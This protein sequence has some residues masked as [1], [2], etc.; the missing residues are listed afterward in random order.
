MN[1]ITYSQQR[2][3][4]ARY[5]GLTGTFTKLSSHSQGWGVH[6]GDLGCHLWCRPCRGTVC[7]PTTTCHSANEQGDGWWAQEGG[8][9]QPVASQP[10]QQCLPHC[11]SSPSKLIHPASWWA[12]E[13]EAAVWEGGSHAENPLHN[14]SSLLE[15]IHHSTQA[16]GKTRRH[17]PSSGGGP[18]N[19]IKLPHPWLAFFPRAHPLQ[20]TGSRRAEPSWRTH[21]MV[22]AAFLCSLPWILFPPGACPPWRLS[23][24]R[25][26][27]ASREHA[28]HSLPRAP[29]RLAPA[30]PI[31]LLFHGMKTDPSPFSSLACNQLSLLFN[32]AFFIPTDILVRKKRAQELE[33]GYQVSLKEPWLLDFTVIQ[34]LKY[35]SAKGQN[36]FI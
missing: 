20:H 29:E 14:G 32:Q 8:V 15:P 34:S 3:A 23:S 30:P 10:C 5:F 1:R 19:P 28:K 27:E 11:C 31:A 36:I 2:V 9:A 22:S 33:W 12:S 6:R 21:W 7:L 17:T 26:E 25:D 35:E 24:K 4:V 18:Q 13:V 16:L